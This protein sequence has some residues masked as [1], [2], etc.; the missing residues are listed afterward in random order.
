[1]GSC[2]STY[3]SIP[4]INDSGNGHERGGSGH[5]RDRDTK[6]QEQVYYLSVLGD[7]RLNLFS[8][9]A[10]ELRVVSEMQEK[11]DLE[12]RRAEV[13]KEL[14]WGGQREPLAR[15]IFDDDFSI[16]DHIERL[17]GERLAA[18]VYHHSDFAIN[19]MPLRN[20]VALHRKSVDVL[21]IS[22]AERA[23]N[24]AERIDDRARRRRLEKNVFT[25]VHLAR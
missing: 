10:M 24:V 18:I 1:V 12:V 21:P 3:V 5:E 7:R 16:D 22:E 8:H 9:H 20:Q 11:S 17:S 14:R 25:L 2:R 4:R 15:L 6:R 23:V 13:A 19:L